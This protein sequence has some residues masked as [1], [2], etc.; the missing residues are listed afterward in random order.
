MFVI[1]FVL[2][3]TDN[4]I[5]HFWDTLSLCFKA[6]LS[7]MKWLLI[8]MQMKLFDRKHFVLC[9]VLKVRVFGT[10]KWPIK[11]NKIGSENVL[12]TKLT[13]VLIVNNTWLCCQGLE[14]NASLMRPTQPQVWLE[15]SAAM[16]PQNWLLTIASR[17]NPVGP[18][19]VLYTSRNITRN[20]RR[21]L[22]MQ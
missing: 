3:Y 5:D 13:Q 17:N 10:R 1:L 8:L 11:S 6:R 9:L 20:G 15:H 7:D 22:C 18:V 14:K 19:W 2:L 4:A 16:P 12:R 21:A